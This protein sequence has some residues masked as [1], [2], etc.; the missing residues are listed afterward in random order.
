MSSPLQQEPTESLNV[1]IAIL[2]SDL[3]RKIL[4]A[5][6]EM[7]DFVSRIR[8]SVEDAA[9]LLS[10]FDESV[11]EQLFIDLARTV[12]AK[13]EEIL[14]EW[15]KQSKFVEE[16]NKDEATVRNLFSRSRIMEK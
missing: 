12:T 9:C 8:T 1:K 2:L 14:S 3:G 4:P 10:Q 13:A 15:D 16:E 5:N 11:K 7:Q 6:N